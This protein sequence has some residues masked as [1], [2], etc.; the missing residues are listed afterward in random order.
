MFT[1]YKDV[2]AASFTLIVGVLVLIFAQGIEV[3]AQ[4]GDTGSAFFPIVVGS[5]LVIL[6]LVYLGMALVSLKK[7]AALGIAEEAQTA[8]TDEEKQENKISTFKLIASFA[9][10]VIYVALLSSVGFIITSIV[11]LF[12]QM[13]IMAEDRSKK[14]II[15]IVIA[16]IVAPFIINFIFTN[17]F[18][19][20]LPQGLLK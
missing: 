14:Q 1:K 10:L 16:A 5:G 15:K 4:N 17:W 3:K 6:A 12:L 20:M 8:L 9:I 18:S 19:L 2:T 11:Y 13:L 7:Q